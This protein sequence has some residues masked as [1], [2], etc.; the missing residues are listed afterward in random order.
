MQAKVNFGVLQTTEL[1]SGALAPLGMVLHQFS[2]PGSYHVGIHRDGRAV[3]ETQFQV[4]DQGPMQLNIDLSKV[5]VT[6][7]DCDCKPTHT[8]APTVSPEGYVLFHVSRGAGYSA[9]VVG[10]GQQVLFDSTR[11]GDGDM[12]AASL[13]EPDKY[14]MENRENGAK[15]EIIV[16]L[17]DEDARRLKGIETQIV[18]C[19]AKMF[20][21]ARVNLISSQGIVFRV[22]GSARIVLKKN[23]KH[24]GFE[25]GKPLLRWAKSAEPQLKQPKAKPKPSKAKSSK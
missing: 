3:A 23:G 15:G 8:V 9:T 12:F 19:G 20:E 2:K 16:S 1:D 4:S 24:Q 6:A 22:K 11:L 18:D 25:P 10:E 7:G 21:P 17:T 14:E 5:T 13:L